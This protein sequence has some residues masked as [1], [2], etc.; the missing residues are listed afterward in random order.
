MKLLAQSGQ[1]DVLEKIGAKVEV[2][3]TQQPQQ[4]D[5]AEQPQPTE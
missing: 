4:K 5:P 1:V 2:A 3:E